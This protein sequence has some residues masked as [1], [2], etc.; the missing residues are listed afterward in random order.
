MNDLATLARSPRAGVDAV[1]AHPSALFA[2]ALMVLASFTSTFAAVRVGHETDV[3]A[4]FFAGTREP[5]VQA[6]IDALGPQRTAVVLYL[7]QRSFDAIVFATAISPLF[8]WLLGSSAIHASARLAGIRR[9]YRPMLLL[10]AYAT[11]IALIPANLATLGLGVGKGFGPQLAGLIGIVCVG[12]LLVVAFRAIQAHYGVD[13]D[14]ALRILVVA[15]VFF[16]L[17]PLVLILAAAVSI[18][19]AAVVLEYF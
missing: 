9:P 2:F 1:L 16:Y 14:R 7:V 19:V 18:I 10:F 4:L 17:I 5:A 3:N 8:Y 12:W 13:R 15:V 6:M 11:A